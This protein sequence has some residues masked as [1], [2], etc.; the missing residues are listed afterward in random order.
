MYIY[1]YQNLCFLNVFCLKQI[2]LYWDYNLLTF[3]IIEKVSFNDSS[4]LITLKYFT[5]LRLKLNDKV[6]LRIIYFMISLI[7]IF[8]NYFYKFDFFL[9]YGLRNSNLSCCNNNATGIIFL[10]IVCNYRINFKL[11][12]LLW[13]KYVI[14]FLKAIKNV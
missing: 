12:H 2:F 1:I 5:Y 7:S 10:F 14:V 8:F 9:S 13:E 6:Y 3:W 11:T 4:I